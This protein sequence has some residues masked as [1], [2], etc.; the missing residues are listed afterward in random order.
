MKVL[1]LGASGAIGYPTAQA[2]SRAG[3]IVYG[4]SRSQQTADVK[5]AAEEIL[6][7]VCDPHTDHGKEIWA[8][9]ASDVDVGRSSLLFLSAM[10]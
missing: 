6:P 2:F 5:F 4:Q 7:V 9:V 8:K 3:H 10:S 1:I